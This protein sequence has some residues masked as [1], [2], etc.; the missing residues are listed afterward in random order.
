MLLYLPTRSRQSEAPV[1]P[2]SCRK[3]RRKK[4]CLQDR[5]GMPPQCQEVVVGRDRLVLPAQDL[6]PKMLLFGLYLANPIPK[7]HPKQERKHQRMN[8][9][10]VGWCRLMASS[11]YRFNRF[12]RFNPP[13]P[14]RRW[15]PLAPRTSGMWR[16]NW[17]HPPLPATPC[18]PPSFADTRTPWWSKQTGEMMRKWIEMDRN[19][20]FQESCP[21]SITFWRP[22]GAS[23]EMY[24]NWDDGSEVFLASH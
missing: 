10:D 24:W 1:S 23:F 9:V 3:S 13:C 4:P 7:N 12:N 20:R 17:K 6:L 18:R 8:Q 16:H 5:H 14:P 11:A 15:R 2:V 19:G 22:W 21:C